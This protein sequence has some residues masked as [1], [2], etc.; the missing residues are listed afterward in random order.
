MHSAADD[1][2]C[3]TQTF[4]EYDLNTQGDVSQL[5]LQLPL[6]EIKLYNEFDALPES[7][8]HQPHHQ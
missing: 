6:F 5:Q 8:E 7:I 4:L 1:C 2:L 3:P